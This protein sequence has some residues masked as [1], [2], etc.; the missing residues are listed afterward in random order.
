MFC[1]CVSID[2]SSG[3]KKKLCFETFNWKMMNRVRNIDIIIINH[4]DVS[5]CGIPLRRVLC[6]QSLA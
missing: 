6:S 5:S 2:V 3:L 1:F 4:V